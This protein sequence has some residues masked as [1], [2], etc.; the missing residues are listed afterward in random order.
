M[1]K[2]L[3]N[4]IYNCLKQNGITEK[5][6]CDNIFC[7][8][9]NCKRTEIFFQDKIH[10]KQIK[11]IKKIAKKRTKHIPLEK[12][13]KR[14]YFYGEKFFVN[15]NVLSPR[16][17]TEIL[18]ETCIN[19]LKNE[20]DLNGLELCT[21]SGIISVT[22]KKQCPQ[23]NLTAIDISNRALKVAKKN[24]RLHHTKITFLKSNMFKKVKGK[25]DFIIANPPYIKTNDLN[26]LQP[27]VKK[28]DPKIAL[29]GK[30]DG[31]HFYRIIAKNCKNYLQ[32]NG[33]VFLEIGY[34]QAQ[35]VKNLFEPIFEKVDIVNDLNGNNRVIV[36]KNIKM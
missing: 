22:L 34:N 9:L 31:L 10:K 32:K 13:T 33:S 16:Q 8:A 1:I 28:H 12:I 4:E 7:E 21:G 36:A 35:E 29:D 11:E 3:Y 20:K 25:F 14:A 27:E 30:A 5:A 18:V 26:C 17:D 2:D 23:M 15:K 19:N 24:A 6:E